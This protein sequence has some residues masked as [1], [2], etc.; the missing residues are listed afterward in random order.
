MPEA[1][2]Q[3]S[4]SLT[5]DPVRVK[6]EAPTPPPAEAGAVHDLTREHGKLCPVT[7]PLLACKPQPS[8]PNSLPWID[9]ED[10]SCVAVLMPPLSCTDRDPYPTFQRVHASQTD[11]ICAALPCCCKS[12]DR[13]R[14]DTPDPAGK[15]CA[16]SCA[17]TL[18]QLPLL[19]CLT[20]THRS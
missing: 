8:N 17:I 16:V 18:N 6:V 9:N 1:E 20:H 13:R 10:G 19:T 5:P 14:L 15:V 4:K 11:L 2:P 3:R 12:T 7:Q